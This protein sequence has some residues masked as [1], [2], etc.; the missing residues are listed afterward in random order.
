MCAYI[1][2]F[3]CKL[4][5]V[6]DTALAEVLDFFL[7]GLHPSVHAQVLVADPNTFSHAVLLAE[8]MA[9]AHGEAA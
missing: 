9:G 8:R 5:Y 4:L 6:H 7:H 2:N 3:H 1:D